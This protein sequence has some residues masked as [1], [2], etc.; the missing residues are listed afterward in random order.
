MRLTRKTYSSI[1]V[2]DER[3]YS[4]GA[5]DMRDLLEKLRYYHS[6]R[7]N[8]LKQASMRNSFRSAA[9][10]VLGTS[11]PQYNQGYKSFI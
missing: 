10:N 11:R 8:N 7:E 5:R 1:D 2:L 9:E 4:L 3:N 6:T